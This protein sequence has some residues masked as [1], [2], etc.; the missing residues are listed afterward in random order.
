ME[1]IDGLRMVTTL[2]LFDHWQTSSWSIADIIS[3]TFTETENFDIDMKLLK[4]V[5]VARDKPYN[6]LVQASEVKQKSYLQKCMEND[7]LKQSKPIHPKLV[8]LC[9]DVLTMVTCM[10]HGS[11]QKPLQ[12]D[13]SEF[14]HTLICFLDRLL[15]LLRQH[16]PKVIQR[17]DCAMLCESDSL[18]LYQAYL[19]FLLVLLTALRQTHR[20]IMAF[21]VMK[22][23]LPVDW[24]CSEPD[25][26]SALSSEPSPSSSS[27]TSSSSSGSRRRVLKRA[28]APRY[29]NESG[30][31]YATDSIP[32]EEEPYL[33]NFERAKRK[34]SD[35]VESMTF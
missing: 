12:L 4:W 17:K 29:R 10:S 34:L 18:I 26:S 24:H 11:L 16:G 6:L 33:E 15:Q 14:K 20:S 30:M 1:I 13:S 27:H 28:M 3:Q 8:R 22:H 25:S 35:F 31:I 5:S 21:E 19:R 9:D 23:Q 7:N 2:A 32:N